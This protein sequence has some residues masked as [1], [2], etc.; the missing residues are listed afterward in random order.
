MVWERKNV[1][2]NRVLILT[3]NVVNDSLSFRRIR[4]M[5]L[6]VLDKLSNAQNIKFAVVELTKCK[7]VGIFKNGIF[8]E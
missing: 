4:L 6:H 3:V 2:A 7:E 8:V 1:D 5:V